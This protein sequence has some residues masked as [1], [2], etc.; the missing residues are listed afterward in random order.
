VNADLIPESPEHAQ[1]VERV[2]T[3]AFGPGRFAKTSERVRERGAVFEP[4]LS[5]VAIR[6]D[7]IV[8]V[9]RI[10]R[11]EAGAPLY[12]L[13]PLGVEPSAR[14]DGLGLALVNSCVEACRTRGGAAIMLVGAESFFRPAGFSV[15]PKDRVIL[16]GPV[17][18]ARV[19]W[20]PLR[21]G[22]LDRLQGPLKAPR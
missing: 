10:W 6:G 4:T 18:P 19:L 22:G 5:R 8:G 14:S 1:A 21:S 7:A 20:Q 15:M 2:L 9:C 12:F 11:I 17:D 13:G 16:P 3:H